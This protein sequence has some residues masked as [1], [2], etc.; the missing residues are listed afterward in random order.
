MKVIIALEV[1]GKIVES[2]DDPSYC[3]LAID[4]TS[5]LSFGKLT[6]RQ[7]AIYV[8]LMDVLPENDFA[9]GETDFFELKDVF[10]LLL[11]SRL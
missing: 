3:D 4:Q 8:E 10:A 5:G 7:K 9:T 11:E 6:E 2:N 1:N